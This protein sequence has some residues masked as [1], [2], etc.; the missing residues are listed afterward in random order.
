M[1]FQVLLLS[2]AVLSA[3]GEG[4]CDHGADSEIEGQRDQQLMKPGRKHPNW[5]SKSPAI[6]AGVGQIMRSE[7][8]GAADRITPATVCAGNLVGYR[9]KHPNRLF[10]KADRS[11]GRT[12][13]MGYYST[14]SKMC[15]LPNGNLPSHHRTHIYVPQSRLSLTCQERQ[16][17]EDCWLHAHLGTC[18]ENFAHA[19]KCPVALRAPFYILNYPEIQPHGPSAC[20]DRCSMAAGIETYCAPRALKGRLHCVRAGPPKAVRGMCICVHV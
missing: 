3:D 8:A 7:R 20:L 14:E 19:A 10:R 12:A 6:A 1:Y 17:V 16:G 4:P 9:G 13:G 5:N 18:W 11:R 15:R 2:A